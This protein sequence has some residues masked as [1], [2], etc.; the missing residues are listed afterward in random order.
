KHPTQKP[1]DL[2]TRIILASSQA[3]DVILD[4]FSGSSTTGIATAAI[5]ERQ[6][7]GIEKARDY[8]DLSIRRHQ[9]F[10]QAQ[11]ALVASSLNSTV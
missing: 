9:A 3:G 4:P 7:I 2:L 10:I 1:I 8:I 5:G 6:F 11:A